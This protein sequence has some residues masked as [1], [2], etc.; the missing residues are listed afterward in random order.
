MNA[1][2]H[3]YLLSLNPTKKIHT[4]APKTPTLPKTIKAV[5]VNKQDN[6]RLITPILLRDC[7]LPHHPI[8]IFYG[9]TIIFTVKPKMYDQKRTYFGQKLGKIINV[10]EA[11][12]APYMNVY[13]YRRAYLT[14]YFTGKDK[15]L[16][17]N[18]PHLIVVNDQPLEISR[19]GNTYY[20]GSICTH[21]NLDKY[22]NMFKLDSVDFLGKVKNQNLRVVLVEKEN[23]L[24]V[25]EH[26]L[27]V[28]I[29]PNQG[30][31]LNWFMKAVEEEKPEVY[32][33][34]KTSK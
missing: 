7:F 17:K 32:I 27:K 29:K 8:G 23:F 28:V 14:G 9:T 31:T 33:T 11:K 20:Y 18:I 19:E 34:K 1:I 5:F 26:T 6:R 24:L 16:E 4:I 3:K 12:S 21:C 25:P 30:E 13:L 15:G 10:Y 22:P 2:N